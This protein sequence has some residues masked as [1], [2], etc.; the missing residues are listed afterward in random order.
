METTRRDNIWI[1]KSAQNLF[2]H[3]SENPIN[4]YDSDSVILIFIA[5]LGN[6]KQKLPFSLFTCFF[7]GS[8]GHIWTYDMS[9]ERHFQRKSSAVGIVGNSSVGTELFEEQV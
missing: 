7:L 1:P 5:A 3:I 6:K 4:S 9:L 8:P 2:I